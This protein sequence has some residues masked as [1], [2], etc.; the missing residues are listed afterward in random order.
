MASGL[1][2]PMDA[3]Q[4]LVAIINQFLTPCTPSKQE[5]FQQ[6]AAARRSGSRWN[7]STG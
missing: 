3:P 6:E 2:Y 5:A 4:Q 1:L 7:Q